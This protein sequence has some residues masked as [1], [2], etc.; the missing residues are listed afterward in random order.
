[1]VWKKKNEKRHEA[2]EEEPA[3][4]MSGLELPSDNLV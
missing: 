3:Q 1:M 4:R 2:T